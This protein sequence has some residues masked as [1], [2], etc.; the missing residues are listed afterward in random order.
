MDKTDEETEIIYS[1]KYQ[2]E[3]YEYRHVHLPPVPFSLYSSSLKFKLNFF[4]VQV[5]HYG[6]VDDYYV[7]GIS[8][9][10]KLRRKRSSSKSFGSAHTNLTLTTVATH[11][12]ISQFQIH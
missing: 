9:P 10:K 8:K 6:R 12:I 5:L 2:D 1:S 11:A 7:R 4:K 3:Q